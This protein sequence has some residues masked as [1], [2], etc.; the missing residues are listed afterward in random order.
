MIE[1]ERMRLAV[2]LV[3]DALLEYIEAKVEYEIDFAGARDETGHTSGKLVLKQRVEQ[4]K[5]VL[6][7]AAGLPGE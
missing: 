3:L 2:G 6:Y 4:A 5:A 1:D 7:V